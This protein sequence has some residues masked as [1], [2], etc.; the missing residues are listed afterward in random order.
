MINDKKYGLTTYGDNENLLKIAFEFFTDCDI[1][2]CAM[3][4]RGSSY[5]YIKRLN[6]DLVR[7]S[8]IYIEDDRKNITKNLYEQMKNCNE[9]QVEILIE[10]LKIIQ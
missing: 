5:K 7:V 6:T 10:I 3:R 8:K 1:V 2:I 4:T 9:K